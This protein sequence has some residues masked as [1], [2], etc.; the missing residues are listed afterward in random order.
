M[1]TFWSLILLFLLFG[2]HAQDHKKL[3][4]KLRS[5]EERYGRLISKEYREG[6]Y[7][8]YDC[9]GKHFVCGDRVNSIECGE[10]RELAIK[11]K[12][13][14]IPCHFFRKY[15]TLEKCIEKMHVLMQR[16]NNR[17]FCTLEWG[18]K[19]K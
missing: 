15:P 5:N 14:L 1:K 11:Q 19:Q 9:K 13:D 6:E 4:K 12:E 7:L 3:E 17:A 16:L 18:A 2:V 8:M 10:K